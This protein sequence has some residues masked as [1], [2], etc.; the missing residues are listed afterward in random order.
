MQFSMMLSDNL[1]CIYNLNT[2]HPNENTCSDMQVLTELKNLTKLIIIVFFFFFFFLLTLKVSSKMNFMPT[3]DGI[4]IFL[5][6]KFSLGHN[7]NQNLPFVFKDLV[8]L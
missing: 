3:L 6:C 5:W 7:S 2:S 8:F 4:T 1:S